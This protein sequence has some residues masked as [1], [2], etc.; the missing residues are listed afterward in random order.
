M[1]SSLRR[2]LGAS[3]GMLILILDSKTALLGAR[4]GLSLCIATVIPSLLPFFVL[5]TLLTAG[6]TAADTPFLRPLEGFLRMPKG[7]GALF[8]IGLLGGYP[9]GA[10][11]V[12]EC[13]RNGN[14]RRTDAE[15]LLPFC[16]NAGPAFLFGIVAAHFSS[17]FVPWLLWGI[18]TLSDIATALLLPGDP[19]A[20]SILPRQL[21]LTQALEQSLKA[22]ARVCGWIIL[23]RVVISFANR[24]FLWYLPDTWQI[25][26][27]GLLEMTIGCTAL[28]HIQ[29]E[30]LRYILCAVLL[31]FGGVCVT[32]QTA[33]VTAPLSLRCYVPGKLMQAAFC[34]LL[35][36][37]TAPFVTENGDVSVENRL[38]LPAIFILFLICAMIFKKRV[39]FRRNMRYNPVT[40]TKQEEMSCS[41]ESA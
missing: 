19:T 1:K 22:M 28:D 41:S 13:Y 32:M 18:L 25:F 16:S 38:L 6:L 36:V 23:F 2:S 33:S 31:S 9:T 11:A 24:W 30:A 5:S 34:A 27:C 35:A 20:G 3:L 10:Q 29:L 8:A 17:A 21:T 4:E 7:S 40:I 15:R 14:L 12:A 37:L 26:L 39:A